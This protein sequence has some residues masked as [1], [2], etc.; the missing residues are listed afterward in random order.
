MTN[1]LRSHIM[2][3]SY[4]PMFCATTVAYILLTFGPLHGQTTS[5]SCNA[6][7]D[8]YYEYQIALIDNRSTISYDFTPQVKRYLEIYIDT[9]KDQVAQMV[10]L[11]EMYFPL[12]ERILRKYNLP[13]EIKYLAAVESALDPRAVSKSEAVGLWQFKI[14]SG[15]LYGLNVS[16]YVDDR[17]DP[18]KAT[19]AACLYLQSLYKT[20]N[21]WHMALAAYNIGPTALQG[22]IKKNRDETS[23]WKLF[24]KLPEAAQNYVPA[25]IAAT[26]I[27]NSYAAHGIQPIKPAFTFEQTDTVKIT[28]AMDFATIA[29][30]TGITIETLRFLNPQ[31]TQNYIPQGSY[32]L[33]IPVEKKATLLASTEQICSQTAHRSAKNPSTTG[34]WVSHTVKSG[35]SMIRIANLYSCTINDIM[36]WNPGID[37]TLSIG[38]KILIMTDR[39]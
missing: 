20:F 15:Q 29:S 30:T 32:T 7:P 2:K 21:D 38:T 11:A 18:I 14:N 16:E 10:G 13:P 36:Q 4:I 22:I 8:L 37:T 28:C 33:R 39:D 25:F 19:E 6:Y 1:T 27:M 12:F 9:R 3:R 26:Y 23:Y 5:D 24:P 17:M 31:F 35:E 34:K